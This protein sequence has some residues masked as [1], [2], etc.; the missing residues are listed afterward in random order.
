MKPHPADASGAVDLPGR[1]G[2]LPPPA[3][4]GATVVPDRVVAR[5]AARAAR[6]AQAQRAALPPGGRGDAPDASAATRG[7]V[8]RVHLSLDLPYPADIAGV[9]R[10]IQRDVAG[11]VSEL[12]GLPVR[13]V[14]V[15]V[16]RL[17][18]AREP[19]RN[20]VQ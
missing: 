8:A 19:R 16:R 12:T 7:G 5:I 18:P 17:L 10:H 11:R 20:R 6:V 15:T 4:R 14:T 13:E 1:S 9:T 3:E 2:R